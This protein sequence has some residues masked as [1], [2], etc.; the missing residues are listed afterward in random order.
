MQNF[1]LIEVFSIGLITGLGLIFGSIIGIYSNIKHSNISQIMSLGAGMLM[2]AA[3]VEL[4]V[5]IFHEKPL[6]VC[7]SILFGSISFSFGNYLLS[8]FKASSRKRCGECVAQPTE[9]EAPNSG[10]AIAIGTIMDAI[11]ESIVLGL[12]LKTQGLSLPL[13]AAI[14]IG[15]APEALSSS[16]G[17]KL[18]NRPVK[19][20]LTIWIGLAFGSGIL[21]VFGY[22]LNDLLIENF[23]SAAQAFGAGAILSMISEVLLPEA[24]H[25]APPFGGLIVSIGF[26]VILLFGILI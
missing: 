14:T 15:N 3:I 7:L 21:T 17:M 4:V 1:S 23:I 22:L 18:A 13:I 19:W 11:P 26:L 24:S 6:L 20:I 5:K 25:E 2:S 16:S 10:F 12:V 8:K 9:E